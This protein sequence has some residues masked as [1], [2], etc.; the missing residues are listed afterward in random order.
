MGRFHTMLGEPAIKGYGM[1]RLDAYHGGG[2]LLPD[3]QIDE[4]T[5]MLSDRA[6]R[7]T[8]ER[9]GACE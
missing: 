1:P 2:E 4:G 9:D 3:Q 7:A 5:K 6:G 8:H